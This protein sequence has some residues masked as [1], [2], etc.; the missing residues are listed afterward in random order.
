MAPHEPHHQDDD[1]SSSA[2]SPGGPDGPIAIMTT[3]PAIDSV[4]KRQAEWKTHADTTVRVETAQVGEPSLLSE[5]GVR[6]SVV[7]DHPHRGNGQDEGQDQHDQDHDKDLGRRQKS[8]LGDRRE[9]NQNV[10]SQGSDRDRDSAQREQERDQHKGRPQPQ[11]PSMIKKLMLLTG[12][13]VLG[14]AIGAAG[15]CYFFSSKTDKSDRSQ[16]SSE[17]GKRQGHQPGSKNKSGSGSGNRPD[18]QAQAVRR[19]PG[20]HRS[21]YAASGVANGGVS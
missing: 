5:P 13:A 17:S 6:T 12:L 1:K 21:T 20:I 9:R 4:A 3:D 11:Q 18:T 7:Q 14:G 19:T 10:G 16:S 15:Y 2:E 8:E